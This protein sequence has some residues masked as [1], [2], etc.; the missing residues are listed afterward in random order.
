MKPRKSVYSINGGKVGGNGCFIYELNRKERRWARKNG[1]TGIPGVR[2]PS[3]YYVFKPCGKSC[4]FV[5]AITEIRRT[6]NLYRLTQ[7]RK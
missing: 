5:Y 7:S 4:G 1:W 3:D 6:M 2:K